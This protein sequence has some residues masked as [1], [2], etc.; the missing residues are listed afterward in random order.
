VDLIKKIYSYIGEQ[1]KIYLEADT[2]A[3][4]ESELKKMKMLTEEEKRPKI[5]F[6][7]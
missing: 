7:G 6:S 2:Y 3:S 4:M 5:Q 1:I